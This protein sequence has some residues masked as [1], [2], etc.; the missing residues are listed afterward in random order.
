[1]KLVH[2]TYTGAKPY[3]D[4]TTLRNHWLPGDTKPVPER[5]VRTL[6]RFAEFRAAKEGEAPKRAAK[7]K[8][9]PE[10]TVD[11]QAAI[12]ALKAK[13]QEEESERNLQQGVLN[14]ID[15]MTKE[16]LMEYAAKYEV[17]LDRAKKVADLR[18][19]VVTLVEQ[20]GAR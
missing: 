11:E 2:I 12:A 4:R 7:A 18:A 10:L 13:E 16:A 6:L 9:Q 20:Y 5:D 17:K 19:E 14:T 1:M 3:T 15:S 8:E